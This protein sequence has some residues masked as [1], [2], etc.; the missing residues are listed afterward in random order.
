MSRGIG[1]GGLAAV[2]AGLLALTGCQDKAVQSPSTASPSTVS[3]STG[4]L[5]PSTASGGPTTQAPTGAIRNVDFRN[6]T[7][8]TDELDLAVVPPEQV[9]LVN[10]RTTLNPQ[11]YPTDRVTLSIPAAPVF[12]DADGDGDLDAAVPIRM[13]AGNGRV[14]NWYVWLWQ[15]GRAV[16]LTR[17]MAKDARCGPRVVAVRAVTEGFAVQGFQRRQELDCAHLADVKA[18]YTIAVRR[19]FVVRIRPEY[20][21]AEPCVPQ[22]F[23]QQAAPTGVLRLGPNAA[24]PPVGPATRY[25]RIMLGAGLLGKDRQGGEWQLALGYAADGTR[26]CG[27]LRH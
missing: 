26:T 6:M 10:G 27:W 25:S 17:P 8:R 19:N 16:Q 15:N 14:D 22:L 1:L 24:A 21:P 4:S 13:D 9:R 23:K 12:G 20:G 5:S 18:D 11:A 2:V 3:P 7:W